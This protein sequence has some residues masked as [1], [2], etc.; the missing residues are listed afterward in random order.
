LLARK[1]D[2]AIKTL[3]QLLCEFC[4][5]IYLAANTKP[6]ALKAT[7]PDFVQQGRLVSEM[8]RCANLDAVNI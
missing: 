1:A 2:I 6:Q 7:L 5:G 4:L 8:K 3:A